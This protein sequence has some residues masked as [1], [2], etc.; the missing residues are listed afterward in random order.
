MYWVCL[1]SLSIQV[2]SPVKVIEKIYQDM[3]LKM[4]LK[5]L[6]DLHWVCL[7]TIL[8]ES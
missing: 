1:N 7:L 6:K 2:F 8:V 5:D 3:I 4:G